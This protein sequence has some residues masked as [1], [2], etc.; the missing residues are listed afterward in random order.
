[1]TWLL[2]S[3]LLRRGTSSSSQEAGATLTFSGLLPSS[4]LNSQG[5]FHRAQEV[6][7]HCCLCTEYLQ[8]GLFLAR[9]PYGLVKERELHGMAMAVS[10]TSKAYSLPM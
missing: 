9:R 3:S 4:H 6:W 8:H 7:H 1:M 2:P 5:H 10:K